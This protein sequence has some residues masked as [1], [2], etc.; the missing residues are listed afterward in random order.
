MK[1]V[2]IG[3]LIFIAIIIGILAV[4]IKIGNVTIGRRTET[5]KADQ[6]SGIEQSQFYQQYL[7]TDKL[8]VM[9]YW[10]TWC[11][12]CVGEMPELNQVMDKYKDEDIAFLSFSRH[13]FVETRAIQQYQKISLHRCDC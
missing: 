7:N 4:G 9:N 8:I 3:L 1:K 10:A 2:F 5:L 6:K 12:P 13:G 11:Q